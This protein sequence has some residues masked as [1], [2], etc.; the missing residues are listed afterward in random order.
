[1][2]GSA[3]TYVTAASDRW[4]TL[5]CV[6]LA[7]R[8]YAQHRPEMYLCAV[9]KCT[10]LFLV[11]VCRL[12]CSYLPRGTLPSPALF[13]CYTCR[14]ASPLQQVQCQLP[15]HSLSM[16]QSTTAASMEG[17]LQQTAFMQPQAAA[18]HQQCGAVIPSTWQPD[19]Y[20]TSAGDARHSS[21][22][23]LPAVLSSTTTIA[24]AHMHPTKPTAPPMC[25]ARLTGCT[26][27]CLC[28]TS[29]R[30]KQV[31]CSLS[32]LPQAGVRMFA[33]S[34]HPPQQ[35]HP[36]QHCI[37]CCIV[38]CWDTPP[39]AAAH[40]AASCGTHRLAAEVCKARSAAAHAGPSA[41]SRRL[42]GQPSPGH[43]AATGV[44]GPGVRAPPGSRVC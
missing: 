1:M 22:P 2:P 13:Q 38:A 20:I 11:A 31:G 36:C 18:L 29:G 23:Q 17:V 19:S 35:G 26:T 44:A 25:H 41:A 32:Q 34:L 24:R 12:P 4:G 28:T 8:G 5:R 33:F 30:H 7:D 14:V 37:G 9:W 16:I 27:P 6:R 3:S 15:T 39:P 42:P 21:S 10:R 43:N 40:P